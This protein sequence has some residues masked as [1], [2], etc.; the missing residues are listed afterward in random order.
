M[1]VPRETNDFYPENSQFAQKGTVGWLWKMAAEEIKSI[2]SD[3][4]QE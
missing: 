3:K 4:I 2:L 1:Y